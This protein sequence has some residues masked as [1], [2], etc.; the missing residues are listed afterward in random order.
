M[1][2]PTT[3]VDPVADIAARKGAAWLQVDAAYAGSAWVCPEFR[4]EGLAAADSL[5]VNPH[6]WLL[7]GMGCSCLWTAR[8][9]DFRRVFS[10]VPEYLRTG[11][12]VLSLSEVSIPLGRSFR[13]LR[14]WLHAA[15]RHTS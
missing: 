2:A 7:T 15:A 11:D 10:L 6:K 8:T 9:E 12:D 13:A 4:V 5:V 3:S 14:L 1:P